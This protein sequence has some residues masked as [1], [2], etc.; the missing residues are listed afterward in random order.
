M[1]TSFRVNGQMV[2]SEVEPRVLLVDL[3]RDEIRLTGTKIGCDTGQCGSCVV[4]L[5]GA[6]V[7]SCEVLA[8]QANGT[9]V[10]TIE[11]I[12]ANGD[13]HALQ[14]ALWAEHGLQ[15]GFCTPGIVMSLLDLLTQNSSPT[16]HEIRA[17]LVGN[18]CRC[19]GY[20][21]VVR[22][23]QQFVATSRATNAAGE[24]QQ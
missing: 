11:G 4:H 18:L 8:V 10:T 22:A 16:E 23:V 13:L 6:S 9:D 20:H 3:L 7:K 1:R 24:E 2:R 14:E 5:N 17:W 21:S 15:C 12:S 19:T